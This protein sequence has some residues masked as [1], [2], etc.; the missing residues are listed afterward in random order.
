MPRAATLL[1]ATLAFLPRLVAQSPATVAVPGAHPPLAIVDTTVVPMDGERSLPHHTLLVADGLIVALGPVDEVAVP[2]GA[3]V[4]DGRGRWLAPGLADMHVH[5]W[6]EDDLLLFLANGVTTVRNMWGAPLHFAWRARI[7][8][9]ELDG[10][11]IATAGPIVDGVPPIWNGSTSVGDAAAADAAVE[12]Q[13]WDGY[14]AIKVYNRLTPEAYAAIVAAAARRGLPVWGHVPDAVGL[15]AALDAG[16]R[17]VEHLTGFAE[18]LQPDD[19]EPVDPTDWARRRNLLL[20]IDDG[21][22][23]ALA[24]RVAASHTWN[25]PTLVVHTRLVGKADGERLLAAPEMRFVSPMTRASWNPETDF[26]LSALG[27]DDF[28]AMRRADAVRLAIVRTLH[29]AGAPLLLGTD[30]PNPFV[31]P[32]YSVHEELSLLVAAGLS[33]FEAAAAGT[34]DAARF[35]GREHETGTVA[36]GL[37]ADLVLL[38]SDPLADVSAWRDPQLVVARGR[39][40]PREE[41]DARLEALAARY[42][43]GPDTSAWFAGLPPLPDPDEPGDGS[44]SGQARY[45]VRFNDALVG[46]ERASWRFDGDGSRTLTAQVAFDPS[47][48]TAFQVQLAWG[49]EAPFSA[50]VMARLPDGEAQAWFERIG[51]ALRV[52]A[53]GVW[54]TARTPVRRVGVT[55]LGLPASASSLPL[56]D[57]LLALPVGGSATFSRLDLEQTAP[58]QLQAVSIEALRLPDETRDDGP[59][60]AVFQ[61][62]SRSADESGSLRSVA[63]LDREHPLRLYELE[64]HEQLGV[65]VA[66]RVD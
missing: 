27:P 2:A 48:K 58:L 57:A 60:L 39:F 8:A 6:S 61:L 20:G 4:I 47:W 18:A 52:E 45:E 51:D 28:A 41:L 55:H 5:L 38:G 59:T 54:D 12:S 36:V 34:R 40:H 31:V 56:W 16:Q 30:T 50:E 44:D 23:A 21:K 62:D 35:L 25:C 13:A 46:I 24:A 37:R 1:L 32:G 63:R 7:A 33:P 19:A 42:D 17:S 64:Q 10:P 15:L 65:I 43:S 26:R 53:D 14:D 66:R 3:Q 11:F 49:A 29:T 9:G 22:L